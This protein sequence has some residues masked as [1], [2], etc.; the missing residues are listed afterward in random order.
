MEGGDDAQFGSPAE[1]VMSAADVLPAVQR[2][3]DEPFAANSAIPLWYLSKAAAE[4]VKVVLCGEG[5]DELFMGYNRQRWA[6]RMQR[7]RPTVQALGGLKF[8]DHLPQ[9][10]S[11]KLNYLRQ[12]AERFRD[13]ALLESGYE[14]FFAGVTITSPAVRERIYERGFWLRQDSGN[15]AARLASEFFPSPSSPSSRPS[16]NS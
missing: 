11:K 12:H 15:S 14:R 6:Q 5:G 3:F 10:S 2:A 8:L 1:R 16:S 7:L 9:F 4:H 13:G